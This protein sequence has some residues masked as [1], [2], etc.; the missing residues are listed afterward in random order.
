[1][2]RGTKIFDFCFGPRSVPLG[3]AI[4]AIDET[5][6]DLNDAPAQCQ[7]CFGVLMPISWELGK[8]DQL[9]KQRVESRLPLRREIVLS[10]TVL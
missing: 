4:T 1:L 9:S 2:G 5:P 10:N 3:V 7:D 8:V 6:K